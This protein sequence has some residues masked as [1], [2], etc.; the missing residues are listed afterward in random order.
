VARIPSGIRVV[1]QKGLMEQHFR[2]FINEIGDLLPIKGAG[3][4]EGVVDATQYRNYIDITGSTGSIRYI[5]ME[6]DIGGDTTKG[7]ILE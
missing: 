2:I 6:A 1:D 7:W 4:P 5:K 3:S